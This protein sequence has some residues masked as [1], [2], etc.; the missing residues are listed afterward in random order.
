MKLE[1]TDATL[2]EIAQAGSDPVFGAPS[3]EAR[4]SVADR[5]SAGKGNTQ[6][7]L[8]RKGRSGST[9]GMAGYVRQI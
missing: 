3:A 2:S 4:D 1:V 9:A 7:P 5:E 8:C 6:R